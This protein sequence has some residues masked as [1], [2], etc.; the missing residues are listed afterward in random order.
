MYTTGIRQGPFPV[1]YRLTADLLASTYRYRHCTYYQSLSVDLRPP[2][3]TLV[4][5]YFIA[6]SHAYFTHYTP[7]NTHHT[8][9]LTKNRKMFY[10]PLKTKFTPINAMIHI[11]IT[12]KSVYLPFI[13][14][15]GPA[16]VNNY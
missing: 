6:Y 7:S 11:I 16:Q 10:E 4:Y 2:F 15:S 1:D 14:I 3:D 12:Q 13:K 5:M 8:L 9:Y